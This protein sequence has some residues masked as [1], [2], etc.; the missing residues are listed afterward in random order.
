MRNSHRAGRNPI[1][2]HLK[3]E[4]AAH[5]K[6]YAEYKQAQSLRMKQEELD[7]V[8]LQ[9]KVLESMFQL[10]DYLMAEATSETGAS[11]SDEM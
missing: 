8:R 10:P 1:P 11:V 9:Y 7:Q 3:K 2:E 6:E 5:A 4:F